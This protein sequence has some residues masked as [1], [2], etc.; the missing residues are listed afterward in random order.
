MLSLISHELLAKLELRVLAIQRTVAGSWWKY[1]NLISPFSWLW[2]ILGSGAVVR[3]L[4]Q[5]F[6]LETGQIHLVPPFTQH[7]CFCRQRLDH[8]HLHFASHLPTGIDLL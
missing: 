7:D 6:Q 1:R 4:D 5:E 2:L 8:Y 3:H